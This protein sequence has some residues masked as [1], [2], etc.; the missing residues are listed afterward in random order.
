MQSPRGA[1]AASTYSWRTSSRCTGG[2]CVQVAFTDTGVALRDSKNPER[3]ILHYSHEEWRAFVAMT[4]A[5][6]HDLP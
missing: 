5:D 6:V 4:K 3:A 2:D 1:A